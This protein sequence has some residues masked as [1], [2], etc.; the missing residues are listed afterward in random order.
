MQDIRVLAQLACQLRQ[1]VGVGAR[2]GFR[3]KVLT[4]PIDNLL[5]QRTSPAVPPSLLLIR[6]LTSGGLDTQLGLD[7]FALIQVD[8][9]MIGTTD[10]IFGAEPPIF[11]LLDQSFLGIG[12][13]NL[14]TGGPYQP[15]V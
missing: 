10:L 8:P 12:A 7:L 3:R 5:G 13:T 2:T 15:L 4:W 14:V 6:E 9:V 11:N 1:L